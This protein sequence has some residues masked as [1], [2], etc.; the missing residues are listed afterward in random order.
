MAIL[1]WIVIVTFACFVVSFPALAKVK[2]TKVYAN[3][4]TLTI[5]KVGDSDQPLSP[6]CTLYYLKTGTYEEKYVNLTNEKEE[7]TVTLTGLQT[8]TNYTVTLQCSIIKSIVT[9]KTGTNTWETT[10]STTGPDVVYKESQLFSA[11]TLDIVLGVLFGIVALVIICVTLLY[12][13]RRYQRRQRLHNFLRTPHTD[14]F[15]SLQ[16]Y[17]E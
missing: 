11:T 13:Y 2:V 1:Y 12:L 6:Q 4:A 9:F 15:E 14:P 3:K 17:V 10:T 8:G 5:T 7:E 16:D